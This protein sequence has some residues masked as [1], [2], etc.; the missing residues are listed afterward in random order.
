[1]ASF[2]CVP[3]LLIFISWKYV[4]LN[5]RAVTLFPAVVNGIGN[6]ACPPQDALDAQRNSIKSETLNLLD[7]TVIP[8]LSCPCS[9]P[10][11]TWTKIAHL[12]MTDP[13]QQCP[14]N[15]MLN[16]FGSIQGCGQASPGDISAFCS[17]NGSTYSRVCG[18]IVAYQ[19]ADTD[20]LCPLIFES[21]TRITEAYM[22]RLSL[23]YCNSIRKISNNSIAS[24]KISLATQIAQANTR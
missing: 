23:S 21:A 1:M 16:T 9:A 3:I 17:A 6:G 2:S 11:E 18:K 4:L 20:S 10:G 19:K 8:I 5:S 24:S 12:D 22:D 7:N 14:T 15:W 13:S